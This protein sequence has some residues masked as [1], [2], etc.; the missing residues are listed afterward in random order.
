MIRAIRLAA[1]LVGA[2]FV[3]V[4]V[5]AVALRFLL[6]PDKARDLLEKQL[7]SR[8]DREVKLGNLRL[9]GLSTFRVDGIH[10]SEAPSF[11]RGTFLSADTVEVTARL[12]PLLFR[13]LV[14]KKVFLDRP[15]IHLM[16]SASGKMNMAAASPPDHATTSATTRPSDFLI[17]H[18]RLRDGSLHFVDHSTAAWSAVVAPI[19]ISLSHVGLVSA[20]TMQGEAGLT[21]RNVAAHVEFNGTLNP[22]SG[23]VDVS[24]FH[25]TASSG[26]ID[27][28]GR[29][30]NV[31]SDN[32]AFNGS[33]TWRDINPSL[34]A[35]LFLFPDGLT[36]N[37]P[38]HGQATVS[39]VAPAFEGKWKM[40]AAEAAVR[41]STTFNKD[42]GVPLSAE[43]AFSRNNGGDLT[44]SDVT[45]RLSTLEVRGAGSLKGSSDTARTASLRMETNEFDSAELFRHVPAAQPPEVSLSGPM[46]ASASID[47]WTGGGRFV[48]DIDGTGLTAAYGDILNKSAG[49]PLRLVADGRYATPLAVD[50]SSLRIDLDLISM[51]GRGSFSDGK[52]HPTYVFRLKTNAFPLSSVGTLAAMARPYA[53]GGNG[54]VDLRVTRGAEGTR[55]SGDATIL[56]GTAHIKN[57]QLSEISGTLAFTDDSIQTKNLTGKID[58]EPMQF[59]LNATRLTKRPRVDADIRVDRLNLAKL[60]PSGPQK[61]HLPRP[62]YWAPFPAS[63][64]H[65]AE[66]SPPLLFDTKGTFRA[67]AIDHPD[68]AGNNL[69][70][71]W[72]LTSASSDFAQMN[73]HVTLRQDNG[74]INNVR[75]LMSQSRAARVLLMPI[76][77]LQKLNASSGDELKVPALER[78]AF[79]TL[80]GDYVITNGVAAVQTMTLDAAALNAKMAGTIDL[81]RNQAVD[82]RASI[83]AR[84]DQFQ[85]IVGAAL[86]AIGTT[87]TLDL[88]IRGTSTD[89]KISFDKNVLKKKAADLLQKLGQEL[90]G[91]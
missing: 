25:V 66:A 90:F 2:I 3:L 73:G 35:S 15:A 40:D 89:P 17:S 72:D 4:I 34:F 6:P 9:T 28:A 71:E 41:W 56:S 83:T 82:L 55:L 31:F 39:G 44:M 88:T 26:T 36:I 69:R 24:R 43:M 68:Y 58:G 78:L 10:V 22:L 33:V 42:A 46:R 67:A 84:S 86:A 87:H 14:I 48:V 70:L 12:L 23:D 79:N 62:F 57:A 75:T 45:L 64:A 7:E 63:T 29:G 81:A 30:Q 20:M 1:S 53:P 77:L 18:V 65:A 47:G 51:S 60:I 52:D 76:D 37:G 61:T 74:S 27:I 49:V 16:R 50:M 8:L 85:G 32:P 38:T 5:S 21:V 13:K 91:K 54:V 11:E 59:R 80:S 19:N